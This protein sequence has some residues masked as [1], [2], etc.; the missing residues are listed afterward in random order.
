[1]KVYNDPVSCLVVNEN[2]IISGTTS[3]KIGIHSNID[4]QNQVIKIFLKIHVKFI[5]ISFFKTTFSLSKLQPDYFK[6]VLTSMAYL[7]MNRLLLLGADNG[8]MK[9]FC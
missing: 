5:E 7:P 3:N 4:K 1:L 6:G 2:Q 9:L 8:E